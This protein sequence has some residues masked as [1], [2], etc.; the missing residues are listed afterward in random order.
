MLKNYIKIA[1]RNI[2]RNKI[3]STISVLGLA[4][5]IT[6][7]TLLYLYV[8]NEL[9]YDSFHA[10]SDRIYRIIEISPNGSRHF[11]QTAPVLGAT[12][13]ESYPEV[14]EMVRLYQP[15]GHI[16][17]IWEGERVHDRNYLLADPGFFQMFD[18]EIVKGDAEDPLAVPNSVVIS[19]RT[20]ERLFGDENP[21]GQDL[22]FNNINPVT[23]TAV[24]ENVPGNSHLQFDYAI[25]RENTGI[26]WE[27]YLND[28]SVHG[29]YTYLLLEPS[30]DLNQFETKLDRFTQNQQETNPDARDFYLQPLNDIYFG[31][32][33]IEFGIENAHGNIFYITIFS[34]IGIFLVLIAGINYMN[35]ATALSA[36]RGREIGIRKAAGAERQQLVVQFLSESVV[37]AF[38]ACVIS[39]FFIELSLPFFNELTGKQFV[40][41][42]EA[43]IR[44]L[45]ILFGIGLTLG[46]ISGSYPAF[47][48]A[49]IQPIR[50]L[51]SKTNLK[52]KNVT[53]RKVLVVTQFALSIVLI[54][55][56]LV[57]YKQMNYLRAAD[58]GYDHEQVLVVDIN[59][60]DVRSRFEAMKQEL[61]T[62]PGVISAATSSRVPG[63]HNIEHVYSRSPESS[64]E[65]YQQ[66]HF[67]SFDED[68]LDLYDLKLA[69]GSNFTGNKG[70]DSLSILI[71]ET[72]AEAL[73]LE[74]PVGSY[75][76]ISGADD[77]IK[78]VGVL[79]DFNFQSMHQEIA[80][81]V[82]GYW[83]NPVE[84][85][86]FFSIKIAG[87]DLQGTIE[88]IKGVHEQ[89]D[90]ETAMEYRFL[91]EQIEQSYK[92]EI[93]AGRLFGIGGGVTIFIAC[94]GLF[95]L[96]LLATETRIREIGIR[97]VLGASI[98]DILTLLTTDFVKLV[99]IAFMIAIPVGWIVMN[100]WLNK[101][102]YHTELG[103][104][105]F[106][107]AGI[108]ALLLSIATIS[109]QAIRAALTNPVES[110]RSE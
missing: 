95:G 47:Y 41:N 11:G 6:G 99:A 15:A 86:D 96:A 31:S 27:E 17:M 26:D 87:N 69:A 9:S 90:P 106:G 36:R 50:V 89:F 24:V 109:W 101:F 68:M 21:I 60:G 85:I 33:D 3:Y 13:E 105:V 49:L 2:I 97:K 72:A 16:D 56:T 75:L 91:D 82:V 45:G 70:V 71:N 79:V 32:A 12:L 77:P 40:L 18:F 43:A 59:H 10:N 62:I 39:Y 35:L 7:A 108:L 92:A 20:A 110:L 100:S 57:I 52:G 98:S 8:N 30:I 84:V 81:L 102:A 65:D 19:E 107:F 42:A 23:V 103:A 44:M 14:Q 55:G 93:R 46:V 67:M 94:M 38:L 28:W 58:L 34:A 53:L 76:D 37:I 83:A 63:G 104:S 88:Q 66:M 80:P 5:G 74:N 25:S 51:K 61:E 54:I 4:I 29:A 1:I 64:S 78:I 48:L 73:S 22:P